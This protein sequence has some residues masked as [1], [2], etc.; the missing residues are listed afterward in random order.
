MNGERGGVASLAAV[1]VRPVTTRS[2]CASPPVTSVK[3][4][5][6]MPVVTVTGCGAPSSPSTQAVCPPLGGAAAIAPSPEDATGGRKRSAAVGMDQV[7]R[8]AVVMLTL[9]V[10]PGLSRRSE[11]ST[12]TRTSYVTTF[13]TV[14]GE[15]RTWATRP[16][17]GDPG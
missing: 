4:S 3:R 9:A 5:S 12:D 16:S 11:L 2:P 15:L 10:I 7:A 13:C 1:L 8:V 14:T 6:A 17:N